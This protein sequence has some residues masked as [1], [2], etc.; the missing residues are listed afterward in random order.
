MK[1]FLRSSSECTNPTQGMHRGTGKGPAYPEN[2]S[3][4]LVALW[5]MD[6]KA[7]TVFFRVEEVMPNKKSAKR[8]AADE[9][10][11]AAKKQS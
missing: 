9:K 3:S 11:K 10:K 7:Y 5:T 6:L 4:A 1:S 8:R 2:L